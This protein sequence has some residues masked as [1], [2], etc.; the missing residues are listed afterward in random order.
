MEEVEDKQHMKY[1]L[2]ETFLSMVPTRKK[3]SKVFVDVIYK[4]DVDAQ[5]FN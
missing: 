5:N 3:L 4:Y 1:H 2:L